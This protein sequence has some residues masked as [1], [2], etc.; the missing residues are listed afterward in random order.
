MEPKKLSSQEMLL[1][2]AE[3]VLVGMEAMA[4][5]SP[6]HQI[7]QALLSM[8]ETVNW[9]Q[10]LRLK[11]ELKQRATA[12]VVTPPAITQEGAAADE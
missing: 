3:T 11:E 7:N 10:S 2:K 8:R 5:A 12:P 4:Q 1:A 6:S 9:L